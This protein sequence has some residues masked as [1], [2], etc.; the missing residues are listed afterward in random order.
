MKRLICVLTVLTLLLCCAATAFAAEGNVTYSGDAGKFVFA[1]GSENS[2]TD[3]FPDFKDV[4]PGDTLTQRVTVKN[5]AS[6]KVKVKIYIRSLGAHEDSVEFL[7][8][9]RLKV[10]TAQENEMAYM[11]DAA[12]N[13]TAQLTDWVCL[14]TLYSGGTV[15]LDVTLE[16]PVTLGNEFQN[17]IGYLDWEFMVEEFPVE[18]DDPQP[19][20]TGDNTDLGL[21]IGLVAISGLG[22][23]IVLLI[24]LKRKRKDEEARDEE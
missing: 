17:Q 21:L 5:D 24:L 14:G 8:Q 2:L 11:F 6:D 7:S 19:P 22:V 1:P 3:L 10:A 9:L 18:D 23:I 4:M 16:V 13:E 12:A 15:N 20:Q